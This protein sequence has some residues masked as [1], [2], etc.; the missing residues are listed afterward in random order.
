MESLVYRGRA[1]VFGDDVPGDGGI[2]PL[3]RDFDQI[4][5]DELKRLCMTPIDPGFPDS[6]QAGDWIVAGKN[7]ATGWFHEQDILA[8]KAHG[9][10]GVIAESMRDLF[11]R[12]LFDYGLVALTVP[13]ILDKCQEGDQLSYD[14]STGALVNEAGDAVLASVPLPRFL[15]DVLTHG[16]TLPYLKQRIAQA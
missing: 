13:G 14:V 11:A 12:L 8:F 15:Q 6:V 3:L 1:R 2:L 10:S 4:D 9:M 7:F 16:G 5:M